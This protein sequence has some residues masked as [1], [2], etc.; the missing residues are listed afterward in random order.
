[1]QTAFLIDEKRE[2][3]ARDLEPDWEELKDTAT[4]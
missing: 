3:N 1:V 2:A 4:D